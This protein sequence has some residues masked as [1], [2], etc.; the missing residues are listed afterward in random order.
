MVQ[1]VLLKLESRVVYLKF[2]TPRQSARPEKRFPRW[3][4]QT[5]VE[6]V[7]TPGTET[8]HLPTTRVAST[9]FGLSGKGQ[10]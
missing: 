8:P 7:E 10:V 5:V 6:S 1:E 3:T 9:S 4:E 2:N